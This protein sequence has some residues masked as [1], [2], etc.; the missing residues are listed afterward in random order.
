MHRGIFTSDTI[1]RLWLE[2]RLIPRTTMNVTYTDKAKQ[3]G[4]D[5]VALQEATAQLEKIAGASAKD[6][7]ATWDRSDNG[8]RSQY[9][10]RLADWSGEVSERFYPSELRSPDH[11]RWSLL[12]LWGDLL[13]LRS[14]KLFEKL[15]SSPEPAEK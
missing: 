11:L 5:L 15:I 2:R 10:L 8:H 1:Q 9:G 14:Q 6:V 3:L 13:Q 12:Q 4:K 7:T